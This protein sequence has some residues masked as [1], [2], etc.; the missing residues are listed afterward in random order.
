MQVLMQ[1]AAEVQ[2]MNYQQQML[3][4]LLQFSGPAVE[5]VHSAVQAFRTRFTHQVRT[6]LM[7]LQWFLHSRLLL[8]MH[9]QAQ[10][11]R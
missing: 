4:M 7:M 5:Q 10:A 11:I 8:P 1:T 3:K 9:A 2:F 6:T